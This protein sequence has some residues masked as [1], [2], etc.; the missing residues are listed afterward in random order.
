[1]LFAH[2]L[3]SKYRANKCHS[4]TLNSNSQLVNKKLILRK[5]T[6]YSLLFV[7]SV[8]IFGHET[9]KKPISL[10]FMWRERTKSCSYHLP[11]I[12]FFFHF[13]VIS[14]Q[15]TQVFISTAFQNCANQ[16]QYVFVSVFFGSQLRIVELYENINA[17]NKREQI[18][19]TV[20]S[21]HAR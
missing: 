8:A 18:V 3:L 4:K 16:K 11:R 2:D 12:V 13:V 15:L 1:M 6:F 20:R 10:H 17:I 9:G 7:I 19:A 14:P 5:M 21:V